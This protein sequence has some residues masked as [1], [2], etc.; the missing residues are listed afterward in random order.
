MDTSRQN[1]LE[2]NN[3]NASGDKSVTFGI[4]VILKPDLD[5]VISKT[6]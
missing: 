3:T 2:K 4:P 5:I 1:K 6:L